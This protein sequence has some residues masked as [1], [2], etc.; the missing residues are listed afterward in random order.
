MN[1]LKSYWRKYFA[2]TFMMALFCIAVSQ[3]DKMQPFENFTYSI[4]IFY[5]VLS[6]LLF[7]W[8]SKGI[9][10]NNNY[11]FITAI[12]GSMTVK[13]LLSLV[14]IVAYAFLFKPGK[15]YFI[16]PFFIDYSCYTILEVVEMMKLTKI[17]N[18]KSEK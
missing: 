16:I 14:F 2:V 3:L 8:A 7:W 6:P 15:P 13:L 9:L 12:T 17:A 11:K 10:S 1:S 5:A 18:R 4:F